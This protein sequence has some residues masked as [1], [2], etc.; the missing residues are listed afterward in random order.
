[1]HLC[2]SA[3]TQK[4]GSQAQP[5]H[6]KKSTPQYDALYGALLSINQ[7]QNQN[8]NPWVRFMQYNVDVVRLISSSPLPPTHE[9]AQNPITKR[10]H[11]S[12]R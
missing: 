5:S 1:M 6:V 9:S 11:V 3:G 4:Y 7:N 2:A 8:Q 10:T 12:H